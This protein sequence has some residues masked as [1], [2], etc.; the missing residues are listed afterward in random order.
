[1]GICYSTY[2]AILNCCHESKCIECGVPYDYYYNDEHR[3]R[4]SCRKSNN[5]Y[6]Q[7]RKG[8]LYIE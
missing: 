5:G 2:G 8:T 7:F 3:K 1:M 6:H 4:P